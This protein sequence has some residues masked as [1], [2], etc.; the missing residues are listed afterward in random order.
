M[1]T[2]GQI[3]KGWQVGITYEALDAGGVTLPRMIRLLDEME[4]HEMN[5]LSLMMTGYDFFSPGHDGFA[6]PVRNSRL[7][8]FRDMKCLNADKKTEFVS[9]VIDEAEKR[10]IG[11][12]LFTNLAIYNPE[13]IIASYPGALEQMYKDGDKFKWL[14]CPDSDDLWQ[15][16]KDEVEDLLT[17][18]NQ[19]NVQS[20]GY[21]RLSYAGGSCYCEDTKRLFHAGTG[22]DITDYN[23]GDEIIENWKVEHISNK[24]SEMNRSIRAIRPDMDVWLHSSC[25]SGWGHDP[26]RLRSAGINYVIPHVAHF[27]MTKQDLFTLLDRI[28]PND[29]VLHFCVRN[30][31]LKNYNIWVKTPEIIK[32][33]GEWVK[34]Y[35]CTHSNLKGVLFFNE[36]TVPEENRKAA[37]ELIKELR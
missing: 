1:R 37:Y 21:E 24:I 17:V 11:I 33:V 36:N 14:F 29:I 34:E 16:E 31:A 20:I 12:Q 32:M 13:R 2:E 3:Y 25:A 10:G 35:M 8:C 22:L 18:Y 6:W 28:A 7:E 19:K 5:L 30:K 26:K 23:R 15:M 4:E 27:Q 9:K